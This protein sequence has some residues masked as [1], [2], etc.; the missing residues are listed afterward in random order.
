MD[1]Y[2]VVNIDSDPDPEDTPRDDDA[3][4]EKYGI[5][6]RIVDERVDGKGTICVQTSPIYRDRFFEPHFLDF[7]RVWVRDGGD[8]TAP[9]DVK[10]PEH[11]SRA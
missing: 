8:L 11:V 6:E 3:V 7:W 4:M 10:D 1:V 2:F 9:P 5:L